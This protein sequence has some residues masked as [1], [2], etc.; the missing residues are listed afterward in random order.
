MEKKRKKKKGVSPV[1]SEFRS[2]HIFTLWFVSDC[3]WWLSLSSVSFTGGKTE[4]LMLE[5]SSFSC[6]LQLVAE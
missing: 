3:T 2:L 6:F 1:C 5:A 4:E